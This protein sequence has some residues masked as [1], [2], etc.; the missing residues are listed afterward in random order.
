[1][2]TDLICIA[3]ITVFVIDLSG[4]Q[5]TVKR[6]IWK[7]CIKDKPYR[8]YSIKP[9][10][11][12]MC[13]THHICCLFALFSGYF[14]LP[15]WLFICMLSFFTGQIKGVLSVVKDMLIKAENKIYDILDR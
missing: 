1:M 7:W 6:W 12:S 15:V 4:F 2:I 3:V 11:C 9:F 5:D 14:T 13:M 8:E 10:D